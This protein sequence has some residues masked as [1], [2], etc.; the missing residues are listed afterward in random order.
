MSLTLAQLE[1]AVARRCGAYINTYSDR[2]VPSTATFDA[3]VCPALRTNA[4]IDRVENLFLLRRGVL[5][6]G[7]RITVDPL[8]RQRVVA[9]VDQ[10]AGRV[11]PDQPW[12]VP[13]QSSEVL[14]FHHLDP[15]QELRPSVLAGLDRC[16][17][18]DLVQAV[19][20]QQWGQIDL[21]VQYPWLTDPWQVTR[22]QY[23]W[24]QPYI[25]APFEATSM[26][27]H[28]MLQGTTGYWYYPSPVWV[29]A[30]RPA[31]SW[32]NG[33]ESITGPIA[34]DDVLDVDDN[35]AAAAGH[36]EAWHLNPSRMM[37]AAAGGYQA[38][39]QMAATEFSR[40]A[41]ALGPGRNVSYGFATL[42]GAGGSYRH[43]HS[44][45]NR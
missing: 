18:P 21:T 6:D 33:T 5:L 26:A 38:T 24:A 14:E 32:V 8:D 4:N 29:S 35:Y 45:V 36:I 16:F 41:N 25:D 9:S 13:P 23:G 31:T 11:F 28:L 40:L 10:T 7:T 37:A 44:W 20:T 42:V 12:S 39:Q 19:P 43:V 34:D 27:G 17:L 30:W 1:Q 15:E 3:V 22:V 2:Q